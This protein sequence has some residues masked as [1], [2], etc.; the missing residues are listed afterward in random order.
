MGGRGSKSGIASGA[1]AG[2]DGGAFQIQQTPPNRAATPQQAQQLNNSVFSD[3]DTADFHDLFGGRQYFQKQNLDIDA[4]VAIVDYLDPNTERG[5][6]YNMSQNMNHAIS[7]GQK[8]TA[9]QRYVYDSMV[10][11]SHNLGYNLN[12]TR[13]DHGDMIDDLLHQKGITGGHDGMSISALKNALVGHSYGDRRILST[14]VNNFRDASPSSRDTFTTREVKITYH[15]KASAQ[16]LMPG[17]G[18]GGRL[19]EMCLAP[20]GTRGHN[21]YRIVDVKYS[22]NKARKKGYSTASLN[23]R[24]IEL[25]V[26][27][28]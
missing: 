4:Q 15:A 11:A 14:T 27:V 5:S 24:Q 26:E 23:T 2:G 3:T 19:G 9:Q 8:L 20:T 10:D 25:I 17:D 18:P 21:T 12:L 6:L 13:Y 7:T 1:G 22:G 28:D 16:A